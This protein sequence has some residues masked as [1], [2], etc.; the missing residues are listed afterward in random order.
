MGASMLQD[1]VGWGWGL[2]VLT[3]AM[4]FSISN[5]VLGYPLYRILDP[6]RSPF[7]RLLQ[8][9]VAAFR[10]RKVPFVSDP[11]MLYQNKEID[12]SISADGKPSYYTISVSRAPP[13]Y[14]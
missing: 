9:T 12:A 10:K 5:F 6:A 8:V 11:K 3:A 2:G 1:N 4:L 7:T 13:L 14:I